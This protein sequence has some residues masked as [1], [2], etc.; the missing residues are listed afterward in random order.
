MMQMPCYKKI[1]VSLTVLTVLILPNTSCKRAEERPAELGPEVAPDLIEQ[2]LAKV[3]DGASL[4]S[5][6]KGQYISYVGLRRLENQENV[7]ALGGTTVSVVDTRDS[8]DNTRTQFIMRIVR[9]IRQEDGTFRTITSEDDSLSLPKSRL[10]SLIQSG[11]R[12]K[13]ETPVRVTFHRF[14]ESDATLPAPQQ[15]RERAGCGGLNPCEM[16][17]HFISF[18]MVN[19]YS[20]TDFLKISFNLGFSSRTP[21]L[22]F[23]EGFDRFSGLLVSDC[24]STYVEAGDRNIYVRDCDQIEDFQK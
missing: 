7:I 16:P 15:V 4:S 12:A 24:R 8:A 17:V 22:P 23:G 20:D 1:F 6:R 5:L 14:E 2:A 21:F 3:V 19:W 11:V 13:S 10:Q 18:D 9:T